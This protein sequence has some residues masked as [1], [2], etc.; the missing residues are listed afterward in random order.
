MSL[1]YKVIGLEALINPKSTLK[2]D[3][4][5]LSSAGWRMVSGLDKNCSLCWGNLS[6][7]QTHSSWLSPTSQCLCYHWK[8]S[9]S[10]ALEFSVQCFN[11]LNVRKFMM[12]NT[13]FLFINLEN[14]FF[15]F[16]FFHISR[17]FCN[18]KT[19]FSSTLSQRLHCLIIL[20]TLAGLSA[21]LSQFCPNLDKM[22][23]HHSTVY[24]YIFPNM[25]LPIHPIIYF[26]FFWQ[27]HAIFDF[28]SVWPCS[29]RNPFL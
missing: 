27:C 19:R 16:F 17:F 1:I 15:F 12:S 24:L 7:N 2:Q 5:L 29:H 23:L 20:V 21:I 4:C 3:C 8:I 9:V 22:P 6:Q 25:F 13:F 18:W 28:C 14:Y 11:G 26:G 10:S